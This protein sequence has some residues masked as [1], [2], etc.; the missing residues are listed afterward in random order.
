MAGTRVSDITRLTEAGVDMIFN[1]SAKMPRKKYYT[2][3]VTEKQQ[4]KK[5]GNYDTIG[6]IGPAQDHVEADAIVFDR[7]QE[8]YRTSITSTVKVKGVE[9]SMESLI[10][11]LQGVVKN[12]FGAAP[13]RVLQTRKEREVA[14][15]YNDAFTD[16]GADGV[17]IIAATHPLQNS[18][19]VNNNLATGALTPENLIKA[20]NMF[21]GLLD[22][23]GDYYD[24]DPTHLLIHPN[25]L[26]IALQILQSQLVA[27]ELSN[28]KNVANDVMP[29][30]IITN[31]Y[32]DYNNTTEVS[33]W[34]LLDKSMDDAGCILQTKRGLVMKTWWEDNNLLFRAAV[35]E[36]Y[37]VGMV[38]PGYGLFGSTGA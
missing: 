2:Q 4:T 10:F 1:K 14:D 12:R 31:K 29:I 16:T 34:F 7:I 38:S 26:Y 8:N 6:D 24:S 15:A 27:F 30:R 22:Q 28:T 36:I 19:S 18:A 32:L 13:L 20:K 25:K 33:P 5:I 17:A 35:T 3:I 37:G 23:A 11:D 9:A 21:N